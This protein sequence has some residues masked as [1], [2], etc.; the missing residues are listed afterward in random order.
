VRRQQA[1]HD[2]VSDRLS[3]DSILTATNLP[4]KFVQT[5]DGVPFPYRLCRPDQFSGIDFGHAQA[6]LDM[7]FGDWT[8]GRAPSG[9]LS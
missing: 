5:H 3:I 9:R 2:R 8:F 4:L 7:G 1:S 6:V